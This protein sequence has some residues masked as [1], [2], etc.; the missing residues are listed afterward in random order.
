M[1]EKWTGDLI[2]RMHNERVTLEEL[3]KEMGI[4]KSYVSMILNGTRKPAGAKERFEDAFER[5][6]QRRA[7]PAT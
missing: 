6:V 5:I 7:Q 2:G 1:P 4:K 3:G